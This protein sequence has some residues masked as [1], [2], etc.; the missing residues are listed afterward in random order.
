MQVFRL[1]KWMG[2]FCFLLVFGFFLA[3]AGSV[4]AQNC[5][6]AGCHKTWLDNSPPN[7]DV[8][9]DNAT[10]DYLPL[11]LPPT[12]NKRPFYTIPEAH[13]N[14]IHQTE[15]L[16]CVSCHGNKGNP[17]HPNNMVKTSTCK[18]CHNANGFTDSF[19][20]T[21]HANAESKPGKFF[22]QTGKG[23]GQAFA[24]SAPLEPV[25]ALFQANNSPVTKTQRIEECSVCHNYA[26]NYPQYKKNLGTDKLLPQVGCSACHDAHIPAPSENVMVG[27]TVQVATVSGTG[28]VLSVTPTD[29]RLVSYRDLKPYK[30]ADNEAQDVKNGM[31]SRGSAF[32]RPNRVI[33]SGTAT[34]DPTDPTLLT[35]ATG[36]FV[37]NVQV[38]DTVLITGSASATAPL[39]ASPA[40]SVPGDVTVTATL[41]QTGFG[42]EEVI[43]DTQLRLS[44]GVVSRTTV[45]YT[46]A[47]TPPLTAT[48]TV[49]VPFSGS[50]AFEVRNLN[51]NAET[52]CGSCHTKGNYKFTAYGKQGG[53]KDTSLQKTHNNDILTQY[54]TAGHSNILALAW[55]E[56]SGR[57][58]GGSHYT[59]YPFDMSITGSGG[60]GSLRNRNHTLFDMTSAV[61]TANAYLSAVN[62][63]S[64][65][66]FVNN[67]ACYQCHHGL[68]A[69]DYMQD[70][71][72]TANAQVL[73]GDSTVTCVTCHDTH[74]QGAGANIRTPLFLSYNSNLTGGKADVF[75]DGTDI[76]AGVGTGVLCLFC[77]QGRESG[78]TVYKRIANQTIDPYTQPDAGVSDVDNPPTGNFPGAEDVDLNGNGTRDVISFPNP[79]YLDSGAI[80]W[81]RN[82]WEYFFTGVAQEY[83]EGIP[84]HQTLNCAGCHMGEAN[85]ENTE[86][87]HTWKARLETCQTCHGPVVDIKDIPA[88]GDYDGDGTVETA[89]EEIGTIN[90]PVLLDSG[91][92]GALKAA[93]EGEG[94]FYNPDAHPYF[95]T[96]ATFATAYTAW[97]SNTLSAAFNL[98][99]A[100]KS[101]NCVPYHNAWYGSQILQDSLRALGVDTSTYFRADI[102]NRT[103]NDYRVNPYITH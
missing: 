29:G 67:Y 28:T 69:I 94:I 57:P 101:G 58:Y 96:D 20:L 72:G 48:F 27:G 14:S 34:I 84:A 38:H 81:G 13:T 88:I 22:D 59:S 66:A 26:M 19:E 42:V 46:R 62:N 97:T 32:T 78:L 47:V 53:T 55:E 21:T 15:A 4:E 82:A 89:F 39:P 12:G 54:K 63:R 33:I 90:D 77:H 86:G 61:P 87:G 80:L 5:S 35:Y 23:S 25:F 43:S 16:T 7:K 37:G 71:Q 41:D 99:W 65:P 85:A 68:S 44:P 36:G 2:L 31:W 95:F 60:V 6:A 79:H 17:P 11:N 18:P 76:P 73:W 10:T 40:P 93:L 24:S 70:V 74:A 91:L 30:L 98:S 8:N 64:L 75:M 1:G 45:T 50:Y 52:L 103:A 56:F 100:F 102:F 51:M 92:Y 3:S 9:N 49:S 83:S